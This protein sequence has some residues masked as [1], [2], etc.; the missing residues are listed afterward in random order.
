MNTPPNVGSSGLSEAKDGIRR[1]LA[2]G[3]KI[4]I[5]L[6]TL[7]AAFVAG[8][9]VF[10]LFRTPSIIVAPIVLPA[11]LL[12][13]GLSARELTERLLDRID[14]L[15]EASRPTASQS[16]WIIETDV[17]YPDIEIP[18]VKMSLPAFLTFLDGTFGHKAKRVSWEV[19]AR[20]K[21]PEPTRDSWIVTASVTGGHHHQ[22]SFSLD[23][24]DAALVRIAA[25]ILEDAEPYIAIR[26]HRFTGA[27]DTARVL[28]AR[29]LMLA[30]KRLDRTEANNVMGFVSE[31]GFDQTG[32][33]VDDAE[34]FYRRA[35]Q[36]DSTNPQPHANLARILAEQGDSVA[37]GREFASAAHYG[38]NIAA[39]FE[40]WGY[41]LMLAGD[42]KNA[43]EKLTHSIALDPAVPTGYL[44]LG[45]ARLNLGDTTAAIDA[46]GA[47]VFRQPDAATLKQYGRLLI[48]RRKWAGAA[49]AFRRTLH[50]GPPDSEAQYWLGIALDSAGKHDAA[51]Q[52][53]VALAQRSS[54][55]SLYCTGVRTYLVAVVPCAR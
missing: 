1:V 34:L 48:G 2:F 26:M 38:P 16:G 50:M 17:H 21:T 5:A 46:L 36:I 24:P 11:P 51:R 12:A 54:D 49:D 10:Q 13:S 33:N 22:A 35:I 29:Q 55:T 44:N 52:V 8:V 23:N 37:S 27:C 43:V 9:Y 31:C 30:R 14:S 39:T 19:S 4:W 47:G 40:A 7:M 42:Y 41:A 25:K 15:R 3:K 53:L 6:P 45:F 18:G 20:S 32:S 28:A